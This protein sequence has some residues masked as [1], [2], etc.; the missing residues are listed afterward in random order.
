MCVQ[1]YLL[2]LLSPPEREAPGLAVE[3]R[4]VEDLNRHPLLLPGLLVHPSAKLH[5]RAP[6]TENSSHKD[7]RT[8]DTRGI[9]VG[10]RRGQE[11]EREGQGEGERQAGGYAALAV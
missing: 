8:Q 1:Q 9:R 6:T 7:A 4:L 2:V 3:Q 10:T 5:L 11:R